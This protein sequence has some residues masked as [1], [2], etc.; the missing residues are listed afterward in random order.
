MDIHPLRQSVADN[1]TD[2]DCSNDHLLFVGSSDVHPLSPVMNCSSISI[3]ILDLMKTHD[4]FM[5]SHRDGGGDDSCNDA[6]ENSLISASRFPVVCT[7]SCT[8]SAVGLSNVHCKMVVVIMW[9]GLF[10][11]PRSTPV[12]TSR[13]I[14]RIEHRSIRQT[15]SSFLG[16]AIP[17]IYEKG[18]EH[19]ANETVIIPDDDGMC[20][21][22]HSLMY[23][24]QRN[25]HPKLIG[26]AKT[27]DLVTNGEH[28]SSALVSTYD[29]QRR[30]RSLHSERNGGA[31]SYRADDVLRCQSGSVIHDDRQRCA[32]LPSK[33]V[34]IQLSLRT[35]FHGHSSSE[36]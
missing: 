15:E 28:V 17:M 8:T 22:W 36:I 13:A 11:Q 3:I 30:T 14:F 24:T 2:D 4:I 19:V 25:K 5:L 16:N 32:S 31:A 34:T 10:L 1:D 27:R 23:S 9:P 21:D 26:S 12:S 35:L 18:F 29:V 33:R 7:G 6:A 20:I